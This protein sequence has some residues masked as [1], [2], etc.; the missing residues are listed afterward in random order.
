MAAIPSADRNVIFIS[1]GIVALRDE[2]TGGF[3]DPRTLYLVASREEITADG[4]LQGEQEQIEDIGRVLAAKF[5]V[6]V[7]GVKAI[8][9]LQRKARQGKD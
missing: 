2:K 3:R 7:D 1:A 5:A 4:L 9:R 6:Y 8:E